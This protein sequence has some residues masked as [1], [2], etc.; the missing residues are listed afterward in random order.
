MSRLVN[1]SAI[2]RAAELSTAQI[3]DQ[4][5]AMVGSRRHNLSVTPYETLIDIIVHGFDM[6][7]PLGRAYPVPPEVAAVAATRVW[8][9]KGRLDVF[10]PRKRLLGFRLTA[11]D[12]SWRCGEGQGVAGPM[13]A[14][15]LVL[16]GRLAALPRLS[17]E[18]AAALTARLTAPVAAS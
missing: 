5:R 11:T 13:D 12:T 9:A 4:I 10:Y 15:L 17:G 16:T 7:V 8:N 18:G 1:R 14:I 3:I 6:T 2:D